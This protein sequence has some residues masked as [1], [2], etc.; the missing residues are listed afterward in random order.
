[1][2]KEWIMLCESH[3]IKIYYE[4]AKSRWCM[5]GQAGNIARCLKATRAKTILIK[6][7]QYELDDVTHQIYQLA[8]IKLVF[9]EL[10]F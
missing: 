7:E 10:I 6:G 9:S 4:E 1:M 5:I 2:N 8:E 3:G